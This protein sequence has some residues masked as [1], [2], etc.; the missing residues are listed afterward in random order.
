MILEKQILS[1]F[2]VTILVS[3]FFFFFLANC[4]PGYYLNQQF[5]LCLRC[6]YGEYQDEDGAKK[7]KKCPPGYT[8]RFFGKHCR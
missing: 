6:A 8:T 4:G 2:L 5:R 3:F 7:C 1:Y